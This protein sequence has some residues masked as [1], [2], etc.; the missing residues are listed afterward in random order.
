VGCFLQADRALPKGL[1]VVV[2][3]LVAAIFAINC[4]PD[5]GR[6]E[7]YADGESRRG[8]AYVPPGNGG[9]IAYVAPSRGNQQIR[10]VMPDG[11]GD[12][13]LWNAPDGIPREDGIG[14]VSWSPDGERIAFDSSHDWHR[15]M[16]VRD[17]YAIALKDGRMTR[18][19]APPDPG[20][21]PRMRKGKVKVV[22]VNGA[23]GRQLEVYVEGASKPIQ[24]VA[25]NGHSYTVMFND[26]A[27]FGPGVRQRV[28]VY[29]YRVGDSLSQ[30]CWFDIGAAA[31]IEPDQTVDAGR[32]SG[33]VA[34]NCP[35]ASSPTWSAG[36]DIVLLFR[37]AFRGG[38]GLMGYFNNIWQTKPHLR[39]GESGKRVLAD[40]TWLTRK[41]WFYLITA[42]PGPQYADYLLASQFSYGKPLWSIDLRDPT[43]A[44]TINLK[45]GSIIDYPILG[46]AWEPDGS[47]Y[48]LSLY[49]KVTVFGPIRPSGGVLYRMD[50]ATS[51]LTEI[52]RLNGEAIG[53]LGISPN[54]REIVFERGSRIDE[55][56]KTGFA[57]LIGPHL[58]CPCSLWVVNRDGSHLRQLVKDG[59]APAWQPRQR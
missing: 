29:D 43:Q 5:S 22:V 25:Q 58:Q 1:A 26:V 55:S 14:M 52:V 54:G 21:F 9:W 48:F 24:L 35:I 34:F 20:D 40:T 18:P 50:A 59:R 7:S 47:G 33:P 10:L 16:A 41:P 44:G 19:T 30:P 3:L 49:E 51:R 31:D 57:P 36:G 23:F 37:E 13:V 27:D 32:I 8:V 17:I 4:Q 12:R 56:N 15:S 45:A 6:A 39:P 38:S 11:S 42:S 53:R 28:R 46:V 2:L